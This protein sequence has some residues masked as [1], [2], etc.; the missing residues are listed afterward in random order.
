MFESNLL[1]QVNAASPLPTLVEVGM[2]MSLT[3]TLYK[4]FQFAHSLLAE[5]S[6][7]AARLLPW[8]D[9]IYLGLT[10][11]LEG[12]LLFHADTT[13]SEFIFGLRWAEL[14]G[15]LAAAAN[16]GLPAFSRAQYLQ[17]L[18]A[19]PPPIATPEER[20]MDFV[21]RGTASHLRLSI[22]SPAAAAG[23]AGSPASLQL[24]SSDG[25]AWL[26]G[27][28]VDGGAALAQLSSA[29]LQTAQ[30]SPYG[31]LRFTPL[32]RRTQIL[33]LLA[34]TLLP[35][36]ERKLEV[37]YSG[38]MDNSVDAV[39]LREAEARQHPKR[40]ALL[41]WAARYLYPLYHVGKGS[42]DLLYLFLFLVE[43]T[44]FPS[45]AHRLLGVVLRRTTAADTSQLRPPAVRALLVARVALLVL[46]IGFR[47]L[48]FSRTTNSVAPRSGQGAEDLPIPPP[49]VFSADV[50]KP[51][52]RLAPPQP[53]VC[54]LCSRAVTNAAV[55]AVSG[56]VGCYPCLQQ[57]VAAHQS[58]P[59]T[60]SAMSTAEI[61]RVFEC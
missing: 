59:V 1:S 10:A 56:I 51:A 30:R 9:E 16:G 49:P 44:P 14:T 34:I 42:A 52:M 43:M 28:T 31:Y 3:K 40:A 46:L 47:L 24:Q 48:D 2:S 8:N 25:A 37:W 18:I 39:A 35:Y 61:R 29:E 19:G 58:C 6:D 12:Q 22:G 38:M 11:L 21:N 17:R 32:R 26:D 15:P 41:R 5:K 57:H 4:T 53:G 33:S 20:A 7:T 27:K 55:C 60:G 23:A 45:P 13:F 36:L 54:P 50:A